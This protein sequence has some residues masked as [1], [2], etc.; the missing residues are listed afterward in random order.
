M[1]NIC[2][3]ILARRKQEASWSLL[4]A[5]AIYYGVVHILY[6]ST[7]YSFSSWD[8]DTFFLI[9]KKESVPHKPVL[10]GPNLLR[11]QLAIEPE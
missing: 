6:M 8:E 3:K 4:S 1:T 2:S 9:A 10:T 11:A 5:T 7:F